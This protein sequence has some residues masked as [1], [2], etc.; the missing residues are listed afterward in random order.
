MPQA[1][2]IIGMNPG[3]VFAHRNVGN[4][5]SHSDMNC[6]SV[7]EYGIGALKVKHVIVCGHYGCGAVKASLTLPAKT[8]GVVNGWIANIREVR[9]KYA[10]N[11]NALPPE[12]RPDLL[13]ELNAIEQMVHVC[14]S[15]A[16]QTAWENKQEL[17]VHA[18]VYDVAT[19]K[20]KVLLPAVSSLD[21]MLEIK[22]FQDGIISED[23]I[24]TT[25]DTTLKGLVALEKLAK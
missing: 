22:N 20:L 15:P 25:F 3:D 16:V 2:D 19:G 18:I 12:Q 13:S 9:N 8:A 23:G 1:N 11:L 5:V 21:E 24:K 7:L 4:V 10:A 14:T 17:Y 6:M